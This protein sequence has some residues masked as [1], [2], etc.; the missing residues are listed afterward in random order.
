[1][2]T[3]T[4]TRTTGLQVNPRWTSPDRLQSVPVEGGEKWKKVALLRRSIRDPTGKVH[5]SPK[6]ASQ[7]N[8]VS[9]G[10]R[11]LGRSCGLKETFAF[12]ML[13]RGAAVALPGKSLPY[14]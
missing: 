13:R 3:T 2:R 4:S 9:V 11:R 5:T 6:L 12:K 1:M 7:Y 10:N 8:K 14:V